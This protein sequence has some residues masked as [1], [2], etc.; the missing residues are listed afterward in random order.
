VLGSSGPSATS[1]TGA[2]STAAAPIERSSATTTGVR[3]A[4]ERG[5]KGAVK[6]TFVVPRRSRVV[7]TLRGPLP[8]CA[9]VARFV[10]Q[11]RRGQN[12]LRFDGR[13]GGRRLA[14]GAYL[15][16]LRPVRSAR[17]RWGALQIGSSGVRALPRA[18]ADSALDQCSRATAATAAGPFAIGFL[19]EDGSGALLAA[20]ETV[21]REGDG[22]ATA[23]P[24][25]RP[26]RAGVLGAE[27]INDAAD[28][29]LN[30]VF[31]IVILAVMIGSL[32]AIAYLVVSY[33]R[34]EGIGRPR[35]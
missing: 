33:V 3:V 27:R 28:M 24:V 30:P 31:G 13:P 16:G 23:K 11:A 6:I 5:R 8:Y 9:R 29:L 1:Q 18:T 19:P 12:T 22:N 21:D 26:P 32:L 14:D 25:E 20:G 34:G 17:T 4:N 7:V 35:F 15:L 10:I 2:A